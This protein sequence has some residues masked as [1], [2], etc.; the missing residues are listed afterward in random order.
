M[1]SS[2]F[3]LESQTLCILTQI[4]FSQL[5][6]AEHFMKESK[7]LIH[8]NGKDKPATGFMFEKQLMRGLYFNQ[9]PAKVISYT[10]SIWKLHG[11][12]LWVKMKLVWLV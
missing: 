12:Q 6:S 4:F 1:K 8:G 7:F 11:K 3:D 10:L 2:L 5:G 9:S